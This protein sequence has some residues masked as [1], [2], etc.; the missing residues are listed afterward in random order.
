MSQSGDSAFS[1]GA[2]ADRLEWLAEDVFKF[3]EARTASNGAAFLIPTL[4]D[5][6]ASNPS[7]KM[8][9]VGAGS[10]SMTAE[11]AQIIAPDGHAIFI[12]IRCISISFVFYLERSLLST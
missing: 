8:L 10:G 4:K 1:D 12:A 3:M 2:Q 9:D 6:V 7:L 5:M 11:F